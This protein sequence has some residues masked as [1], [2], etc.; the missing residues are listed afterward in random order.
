MREYERDVGNSLGESCPNGLLDP[1]IWSCRSGA[2]KNSADFD[3]QYVTLC[4]MN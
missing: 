4:E 3:S 2:S 1:S